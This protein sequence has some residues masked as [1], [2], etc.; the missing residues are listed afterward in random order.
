[1]TLMADAIRLVPVPSEDPGESAGR[2]SPTNTSAQ[3]PAAGAAL[4][5]GSM[6]QEEGQETTLGA[7]AIRLAAVPSEDPGASAGRRPPT[8]HALRGSRSTDPARPAA[9]SCSPRTPVVPHDLPDLVASSSDE[10]GADGTSASASSGDE[11]RSRTGQQPPSRARRAASAEA[12]VQRTFQGYVS[13][14]AKWRRLQADA[15]ECLD[16]E[17]L[18]LKPFK[19]RGVALWGKLASA[20]LRQNRSRMCHA[21]SKSPRQH[22]Q[23]DT[24]QP[25]PLQPSPRFQ[26]EQL[27]MQVLLA[28]MQRQ[29]RQSEQQSQ[30][31]LEQVAQQ[32]G[33][34]LAH[35]AQQSAKLE[36]NFEK[37]ME[38][39]FE[40]M[41][42]LL[43]SR[44]AVQDE[45]LAS[46]QQQSTQR[47]DHM[48]Q[49]FHKTL[50]QQ[51]ADW[52]EKLAQLQRQ[53]DEKLVQMEEKLQGQ[54]VQ[55][56]A[57][58]G[59][60]LQLLQEQQ[61]QTQLR[62]KDVQ[63]QLDTVQN[64]LTAFSEEQTNQVQQARAA[65]EAMKEEIVGFESLLTEVSNEITTVME[66]QAETY[67]AAVEQ[68][69]KKQ[70]NCHQLFLGFQNSANARIGNIGKSLQIL[71][72]K[73]VHKAE[74][75]LLQLEQQLQS[76]AQQISQ[77][78]SEQEHAPEGQKG[79]DKGGQDISYKEV[80]L[81]PSVDALQRTQ[82]AQ[83]QLL[84]QLLTDFQSNT[85]S[86]E[87]RLQE[88]ENTFAAIK[89][90]FSLDADR[91]DGRRFCEMYKDLLAKL[92]Q[93]V[94]QLCQGERQDEL[95]N[96]ESLRINADPQVHQ[97]RQHIQERLDYVV[98]RV[99]SVEVHLEHLYS[100]RASP[101]GGQ[102]P[103]QEWIHITQ[104]EVMKLRRWAGEM[105]GNVQQLRAWT[106]A[107]ETTVSQI[108]APQQHSA[109][110]QGEQAHPIELEQI[111]Q[112]YVHRLEAIEHRMPLPSDDDT[113]ADEDT[114][115]S[116]S[117]TV[118]RLVS[119][120]LMVKEISQSFHS[121]FQANQ[122]FLREETAAACADVHA[123]LDCVLHESNIDP[124]ANSRSQDEVWQT[125]QTELA[126]FKQQ[127][128]AELAKLGDTMSVILEEHAVEIAKLVDA[129]TVGG[130]RLREEEV[131]GA[132]TIL[133]SQLPMNTPSHSVTN[134]FA[135]HFD[136]VITPLTSPEGSPEHMWQ[137]SSAW[138]SGN[139]G[140]GGYVRGGMRTG[141]AG[142][143]RGGMR[144]P[145]PQNEPPYWGKQPSD[146]RQFRQHDHRRSLERTGA[147]TNTRYTDAAEAAKNANRRW[148]GSGPYTETDGQQEYAD[149]EGEP[150]Q[151]VEA[152][153]RH[154][155]PVH[156]RFTTP[157]AAGDRRSTLYVPSAG[158]GLESTYARLARSRL[159]VL[160]YGRQMAS[161]SAGQ[162]GLR[163]QA[164]PTPQNYGVSPSVAVGYDGRNGTWPGGGLQQQQPLVQQSFAQNHD[165]TWQGG[166]A[167][168][169][170]P[171][172]Q[173]SLAQ[174]YGVRPSFDGGYNGQNG[175]WR[176]GS[177]LQQQSL[178]H[179]SFAQNYDGTWQGGIAQQQ[180]PRV[181]QSLAQPEYR[182]GGGHNSLNAGASEPQNRRASVYEHPDEPGH[183]YT[184]GRV[185]AAYLE[186]LLPDWCRDVE[187]A[188]RNPAADLQREDRL[189]DSQVKDP[190]E[191]VSYHGQTK[192]LQMVTPENY[193]KMGI[194]QFLQQF[195]YWASNHNIRLPRHLESSLSTAFGRNT[196]CAARLQRALQQGKA[197][198]VRT[199]RPFSYRWM[200]SIILNE[201]SPRDWQ[202]QT[203]VLWRESQAQNFWPVKEWFSHLD[204]W[205]AVMTQVAAAG[206]H[207]WPR[208]LQAV[209]LRY[210]VSAVL[211][212]DLKALPANTYD[213][214]DPDSVREAILEC[215][216]RYH[217]GG[218]DPK[219]KTAEAR[220]T[221]QAITS[222]GSR[223]AAA[224]LDG[225][226]V[227]EEAEF[228][229]LVGSLDDSSTKGR[230]V[231][232]VL[233]EHQ[234]VK[235]VCK[236]LEYSGALADFL[237]ARGVSEDL[238][239]NRK[240]QRGV[241]VCC[242]EGH[243]LAS[244]PI[245]L[246]SGLNTVRT[247]ALEQARQEMVAQHR[248]ERESWQGER[249]RWRGREQLLRE[250]LVAQQP[251]PDYRRLTRA[252]RNQNWR[253]DHFQQAQHEVK[254][255]RKRLEE[256]TAKLTEAQHAESSQDGL[257]TQADS[258]RR[259]PKTTHMA[260]SVPEDQQ[261]W[262]NYSTS[263]Y[264]GLD[265]DESDTKEGVGKN[266]LH[267]SRQH[268]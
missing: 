208:Q 154:E 251:R 201:F 26:Q 193:K 139:A 12:S 192:S 63:E 108:A 131:S 59:D 2:R 80:A 260:K 86:L 162:I 54:Q 99:K 221:E 151:G 222:G 1:M 82:E 225:L 47:L 232:K 183:L 10:P 38:Q 257:V 153:G 16:L 132:S 101:H 261:D 248:Q 6:S 46:F 48:G 45:K 185:L 60:K 180:Q 97:W 141:E 83:E 244:C 231:L 61:M 199:D 50:A 213:M 104:T 168:Q 259:P 220:R 166:I 70:T 41:E 32:S 96:G 90:D 72:D 240:A 209:I 22:V 76:L 137:G 37:K 210:G 145:A 203:L 17:T 142:H 196:D 11:P 95:S 242:G 94:K 169:Q 119:E 135:T 226:S 143:G 126:V 8:N 56:A 21:R 87:T 71:A 253:Q 67:H 84:H 62:E 64:S 197:A 266:E 194:L 167:P 75:S 239:N 129:M 263:S 174:N 65:A 157:T 223:A 207:E 204:Q 262:G 13:E 249:D 234:R 111:L 5:S 212:K 219:P 237:T 214:S 20:I 187:E 44:T 58:Q 33:Q 23:A 74:G 144:T 238:F 218:A 146:S 170:Q 217:D 178:V 110:H 255:A 125:V 152:E 182:G 148:R 247:R 79:V 227:Q 43:E 118:G 66:R 229:E 156:P 265:S 268:K 205:T 85:A 228:E 93:Q 150:A 3:P 15:I 81:R 133:T 120:E 128:E 4:T 91:D 77:L 31:L 30:Q 155:S 258:R 177:A 198:S 202:R 173:Q 175:T 256:A 121:L 216:S 114:E 106:H 130:S 117:K 122:S 29:G 73:R 39:Q 35:V 78:K 149:S 190:P 171:R 7:G 191:Y 18:L 28:E 49:E 189:K 176:G 14:V 140:K 24:L 40:K 215:A 160:Q 123:R 127:Q 98:A 105:E 55:T 236:R 246:Q 241:C 254:M 51:S 147:S 25:S 206:G 267:R 103:S 250:Q 230:A 19:K 233:Q 159:A 36:Q 53:W 136:Q 102:V 34:L 158:G 195:E 109:L 138:G 224:A 165:G 27:N 172:V 243:L 115:L 134:P 181:Q 9:R 164:V 179:Q 184:A 88:L 161:Y 252:G 245:Y 235:E 68:Q 89:P 116:S 211:D 124:Q 107:L 112:G 57:A 200:R 264:D 163:E 69:L 100:L 188:S 42:G 186:A 92:Q 52:A 113:A